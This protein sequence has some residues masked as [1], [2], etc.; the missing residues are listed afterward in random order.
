MTGAPVTRDLPTQIE[1]PRLIIRCPKPGDGPE[2]YRAIVD[3]LE[4]LR[5]FPAFLPWAVHEPGVEASEWYCRECQ[6]K[7][8]LRTQ[9]T[10]HLFLKAGNVLVGCSGLHALEWSV[11]KCE[12]GYWLR[13]GF[14]RQGLATE[15][16][17]AITGFAFD[18]LGMRRVEALTD[19][20]NLASCRVC[21]RTGYA[22]E[23][24]LRNDRI[25]PNGQ[26]RDTRVYAITR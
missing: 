15:A 4:A 23:G 10:M 18:V 11:P 7:Y 20:E 9:M 25:Q 22:L 16:F 19:N 17:A 21:E 24:V 3:S 12:A 6:A 2:L 26:L 5:Q 14:H 1:T 13:T 8:L